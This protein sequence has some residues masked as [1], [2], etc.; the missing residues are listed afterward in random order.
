MSAASARVSLRQLCH[1]G[2]P[3][4]LLLPALLPVLRE[5]VWA[6]HA[7]F[8]FCDERGSITNL[9]AERLLAPDAMAR[10]HDQHSS[11]Q[12]RRQYLARVAAPQ[13]MSRR[14]IDDSERASA[15]YRD[16][17]L[18]LGI[19]HF[20]YAIVRHQGRPLGQLSLY[21]SLG[22][23]AFGAADE[24]A[25]GSVEHYLG[26]ALAVPSP[27]ALQEAQDH[28]VE[29]GLALLDA[30]GNELFADGNWPR[31]VRMAHGD[32]IAPARALAERETLPR[33]VAAV[34][35]AV[36]S[37][38]QAV[39]MVSSPW[40]QF[41]FRRHDMASQQGGQ[42][43][44]LL[45][46]RLAAEPLRLAQGAAALGLAPQQREVAVLMAQ[47]HSNTSIA[48]QLGITVNTAG[49]HAKQVFARLQV[50][51]RSAIAKA[52]GAAAARP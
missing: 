39:H 36:V 23:A 46:S 30:Q 42:A 49:Y 31:L 44:A 5:L 32:A 1:L 4:Q 14:S 48:R 8:F 52:L 22:D 12:F 20:L 41:V 13:A 28:T 17:L 40:G 50:H 35:A 43:V 24:Q 16:V 11:Q 33:F 51:D 26:Q 2:L 47:G 3:A 18:P 29:E 21:R 10:Y 19:E 15:Y 7:G 45:V 25:I 38:P 34:L 6:R 27:R 37:A 9:Y